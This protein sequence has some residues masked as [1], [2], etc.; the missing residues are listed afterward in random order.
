M[1]ENSEEIRVFLS[2]LAGQHVLSRSERV[3]NIVVGGLVFAIGLPVIASLPFLLAL[4]EER[5]A[6]VTHHPWL[7]VLMLLLSALGCAFIYN[8]INTV[9]QFSAS[10]V[11]RIAP[12]QRW[13]WHLPIESIQNL[14]FEQSHGLMIIIVN[15]RD[16][17]RRKV[18]V[19][20]S[21]RRLVE[22]PSGA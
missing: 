17:K 11:A 9:W 18:P 19:I 10:S 21:M 2:V 5:L 12:F 7:L 16:G 8:H 4:G 20:A 13:S 15:L 22:E 6:G 14:R 3:Q 1:I